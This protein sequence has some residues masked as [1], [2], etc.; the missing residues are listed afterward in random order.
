MF[1]DEINVFAVHLSTFFAYTST[2][3]F[4]FS[5]IL[6]IQR[7]PASNMS[8]KILL[9]MRKNKNQSSDAYNSIYLLS[10]IPERFEFLTTISK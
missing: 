8:R 7:S 4:H 9:R 3:R 10:K 6:T 1:C 2:S 5:A